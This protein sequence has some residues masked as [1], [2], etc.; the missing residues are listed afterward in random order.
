MRLLVGIGTM[1]VGLTLLSVAGETMTQEGEP[2]QTNP[3]PASPGGAFDPASLSPFT[4]GKPYLGR[5]ETG[6]YGGGGN[7]MPKAHQEAGLRLAAGIQPLDASG[8]ADAESGKIIALVLGHSNTHD[9]FSALQEHFR[10]HAARLRGGFELLDA[11]VGGQ[12]LPEIRPLKGR[13]WDKAAALLDRPGY[14]PCQVQV[15][16]LHTTYPGAHNQAKRPPG[17]FPET[18]QK[19]RQDLAAVL[20]HCARIYPNLKLAYLTCDGLRHYTGFEPHVWQE[21]FAVKWLIEAQVKG[22]D[23]AAY[24][25]REAR[26]GKEARPRRLPWLAWGPYIWDNTWDRGY[27][28]DGVH[29]AAKAREIFVGKYAKFLLTDP[30]SKAWLARPG[31]PEE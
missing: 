5:Y 6:L 30:V 24:E 25:A 23:W 16:F 13:V 3:A 31:K 1:A 7:E 20:E 27:F 15:L 29:P 26:D 9:Y 22:E 4:E 19:M 28:T 17:P 11:A 2:A 18:M 8:K 12:Q 10:R 14:S 21:A